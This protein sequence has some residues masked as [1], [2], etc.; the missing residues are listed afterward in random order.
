MSGTS[1]VEGKS[2]PIVCQRPARPAFQPFEVLNIREP[3][4]P[5]VTECGYYALNDLNRATPLWFSTALKWGP[6]MK[7]FM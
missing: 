7:T 1:F 5:T 3:C 4:S 2:L 6:V